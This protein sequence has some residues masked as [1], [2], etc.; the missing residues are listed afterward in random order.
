MS[1]P[2]KST[3]C[4]SPGEE[5]FYSPTSPSQVAGT[6]AYGYT[7]E[8]MGAYGTVTTFDGGYAGQRSSGADQGNNFPMLQD[9]TQ[10]FTE[11]R[12]NPEW[13]LPVH[14]NDLGLPSASHNNPPVE[15]W[16]DV[17]QADVPTTQLP[18][19]SMPNHPRANSRLASLEILDN[20]LIRMGSHRCMPRQLVTT[21]VPARNHEREFL[22]TTPAPFL[23]AGSNETLVP[24]TPVYGHAGM[25]SG[26]FMDPGIIPTG[27][28]DHSSIAEPLVF[29]PPISDTFR[30]YDPLFVSPYTSAVTCD[31]S[32]TISTSPQTARAHEERYAEACHNQCGQE[33]TGSI[34][35]DV[36]KNRKRHEQHHCRE[37]KTDLPLLRCRGTNCRGVYKR[38]DSRREHERK[39]H[40]H[41]GLPPPPLTRWS[42]RG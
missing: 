35:A 34:P 39:C 29:S 32:S 24:Y 28:S 20:N 12:T 5:A 3:P 25:R 10:F 22:S 14:C 23:P 40:S 13:S 36:R 38:D 17:R 30:E 27:R 31:D 33:F 15:T 7:Q 26:F 41:E 19:G 37:R 42:T 11:S 1:H 8:D 6:V 21:A 2:S 9:D 16:P 4:S 18:Y